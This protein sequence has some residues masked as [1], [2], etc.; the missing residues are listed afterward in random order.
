VYCIAIWPK[1]NVSSLNTSC[2][3]HQVRTKPHAAELP[4]STY[5]IST[6]ARI[7]VKILRCNTTS[8][9]ENDQQSDTQRPNTSTN[10]VGRKAIQARSF[11]AAAVVHPQCDVVQRPTFCGRDATRLQGNIQRECG[12][13]GHGIGEHSPTGAAWPWIWARRPAMDAVTPPVVWLNAQ[14]INTRGNT[15]PV[16]TT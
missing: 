13:H 4:V 7:T 16:G 8:V 2:E 5:H 15:P 9:W 14:S 12:A 10:H 3:H 1:W 11:R 6:P